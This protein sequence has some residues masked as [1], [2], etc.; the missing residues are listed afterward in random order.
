MPRTWTQLTH[1]HNRYARSRT[2]PEHDQASGRA[3]DGFIPNK[4]E[5]LHAQLLA[6][7][8]YISLMDALAKVRNEEIHLHD[9]DLLQ[10]PTAWLLA[11]RLVALR[12]LVL[13]L[14]C[15]CV[16]SCVTVLLIFL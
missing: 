14:L 1:A 3:C 15:H 9:T 8:P 16:I 11:L 4:F 10:S 13:L 12:L 7:R 6:R 5:P 2:T